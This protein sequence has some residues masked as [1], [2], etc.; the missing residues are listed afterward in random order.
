MLESCISQATSDDL[1]A[2]VQLEQDAYQNPWSLQNYQH[3]LQDNDKIWLLKKNGILLAMA[4]VRVVADEAEVFRLTVAKQ[5]RQ[6]GYGK[7][8]FDVIMQELRAIACKKIFLEVRPSAKAAVNIYLT[9]GFKQIGVRK[10]YYRNQDNTRE[11][12]IIME[13]L[14]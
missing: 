5:Y 13:K 7:H 12:A 4:V 2:I 8:M 11:D 14:L 3:S 9:A 6:L 10:D 1:E